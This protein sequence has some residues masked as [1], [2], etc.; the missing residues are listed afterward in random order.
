M[1]CTQRSFVGILLL[2]VAFSLFPLFSF[3][4]MGASQLNVIP[5]TSANTL[6]QAIA[7]GGVTVSNASINCSGSGSG[8]FINLGTNLGLSGGII[9][10]T[11]NAD[12]ASNPGNF[13]CSINENH[14]FSDPDLTAIVS[15]ANLDVCILEF[16]FVPTCT[17]L[18]MTYVFGSEEYPQGVGHYNDA[19]GIFLT[20]PNPAG[21]NYASQNIATLPSGAPVSINNVNATTNSTYFYDNY[22]SPNNDIA[23]NGYTIPIT[24]STPVVPCST[25]HTKIAIAD[26]GNALYDS[27]VLI[28]NNGVSCQVPATITASST[29]TSG[30][31]N[32]GSATASVTNFT[33]T[34]TYH[35]LPGGQTTSTISNVGI[36]TYSC[37]VSLHQTCGIITQTVTTTVTSTGNNIVLTSSQTN[38][39][40]NG[41]SNGSATVTVVGGTAPYNCVWNTSPVQNGLT[42]NNLALGTYSG[43]VTDN[44]GCQ[45]IIAIHITA[46]PAMQLSI[47]T[48]SATCTGATGIASVN[49]TANGTAPYTYSWNTTPVQTTQAITNLTHGTYSVTITGANSCSVTG[50]ANV[51][52]QNPAWTL[53]AATQSNVACFGGNNGIIHATINN[54]GASTF[55]Y[56]WNTAPVQNSQTVSNLSAGTYTCTVTDNNGCI[57]SSATNVSQPAL[58]TSSVTSAPTICSGNVGS[59]SATAIG[60]TAPYTYLW[61]NAQNTNTIQGLSSGQYSIT[62][63]DAHNCTTS[64][65]ASVSTSNPTLQATASVVNS[66]CGGPTGAINII[67][68]VNGTSPYSFSW[69]TG[70]TAQNL[71]NL[72]PGIYV[73]SMTDNNGCSGSTSVTVPVSNVL[74]VHLGTSSDFC[75]QHVGSATAI[76]H[77]NA[78]YNYIW[79]TPTP[80][81]TSTASN[82]PAGNYTVVVTDAYNCKDTSVVSVINQNDLF[83]PSFHLE[84]ADALFSEDPITIHA[85]TNNGWTFD[86][87]TLSDGTSIPSLTFDHIF[88]QQGDYFATYYFTSIHGCKDSVIYEIK[89]KDEMTLYIPNSFT[90]NHDGKNDDYMVKGTMIQTFEMYIYDRWDNLVIKLEDI[91]QGW[92]GKYKGRDAPAGIYVYKGIAT[93]AKGEEKLFS[94]HIN[95]LR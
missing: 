10:S 59:V 45:S 2:W 80:Q 61:S 54:P 3:A 42:V 22:T 39:T 34:V 27:G 6:A 51:G 83:T 17:S 19:F 21:G 77:G 47:A 49:V 35:W 73:I 63:T 12:D 14:N 26:G 87:G 31:G 66:I 28:S 95:L 58:L 84:P 76:P 38:L 85:A 18:N 70:Q 36:G 68:I 41:A 88:N 71:N 48:S 23:Y 1:V 64:S 67:S 11:G 40:C 32:T 78:P 13:L 93:N 86:N 81:T 15:T 55:T 30:C 20:G 60:G 74:P 89:I 4:Q 7:G 37:V 8:T 16:D 9:L 46:P 50:V 44:G 82:L 75:D 52:T 94:G 57:I 25:Y 53:T 91:T 56:S 65:M 92:N 90:P 62:I 33:G 29:A 72:S 79:S 5:V 24:S 43:T 69:A